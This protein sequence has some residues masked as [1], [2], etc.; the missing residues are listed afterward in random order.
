MI[1]GKGCWS[2]L[3]DAAVLYPAGMPG[4]FI[5][6]KHFAQTHCDTL[7]SHAKTKVTRAHGKDSVR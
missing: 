2:E 3:V 4:K 6:S 7:N 5:L 1:E